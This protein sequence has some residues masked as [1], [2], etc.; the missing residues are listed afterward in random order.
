MRFSDI[1]EFPSV[2]D[3]DDHSGPGRVEVI[4]KPCGGFDS[5]SI[6]DPGPHNIFLLFIVLFSLFCIVLLAFLS[7]LCLLSF[8][9]VFHSFVLLFFVLL[10]FM[11]LFFMLLFLCCCFCEMPAGYLIVYVRDGLFRIIR[12]DIMYFN[13]YLLRRVLIYRAERHLF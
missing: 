10:F 9:V 2:G 1:S 5:S 6:L 8:S 7:F 13:R 11:F 12:F 3:P 4:L